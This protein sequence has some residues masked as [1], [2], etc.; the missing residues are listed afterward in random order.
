VAGSKCSINGLDMYYEIHGKGEPLVMLHGGMSTIGDFSVVL[1][2]LAKSRRVIAV[3][4]QG[5]GHTADI[6]RPL[7]H[8]QAADDT[9]ALLGQLGIK[10]ADFF[11]YSDGGSIALE[12]AIRHPE[13]VRKLALSSAVYSLDGYIPGIKENLPHMTADALPP[14]MREAYESVAPHP[15]DW[16]KL[17]AKTAESA[18]HFE[19]IQPEKIQALKLKALVMVADGDII[20]KEHAEELARLLNADLAVLPKSDHSSYL[21]KKPN[22]LLS[23]LTAFLN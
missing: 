18:E 22:L 17:V 3:E 10:K 5:H 11:G 15:K 13:L 9:A 20:R 14:Q 6:D 4:Q 1:P 23:K 19:D 7:S 21:F 2:E 8:E 16:A 12:I